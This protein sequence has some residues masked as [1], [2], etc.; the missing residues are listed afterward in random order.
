[1]I[2]EHDG[3]R[4]ENL[5]HRG[6]RLLISVFS[7]LA[8]LLIE[9]R[10]KVTFEE[11]KQSLQYLFVRSRY[12]RLRDQYKFG[13]SEA[14]D[15]HELHLSIVQ[16]LKNSHERNLIY[17]RVTGMLEHRFE[18]ATTGF[19]HIKNLVHQHGPARTTSTMDPLDI[20]KEESHEELAEQM[21]ARL[22]ELRKFNMK[23]IKQCTGLSFPI[24][25][26]YMSLLRQ[27]RRLRLQ[28]VEIVPGQPESPAN[29]PDRA[30]DDDDVG[31]GLVICTR[32]TT[33]SSLNLGDFLSKEKTAAALP[34]N[35]VE[36]EAAIRELRLVKQDLEDLRRAHIELHD[37]HSSHTKSTEATNQRLRQLLVKQS[38]SHGH[39][40]Q[41]MDVSDDPTKWW[42]ETVVE[43]DPGHG[44][45]EDDDEVHRPCPGGCGFRIGPNHTTHC[46]GRCRDGMGHGPR[47]LQ[48]P[49]EASKMSKKM[50]EEVL[51]PMRCVC[52]LE[53][54][55]GE[56]YC[57]VC[58]ARR[59]MVFVPLTPRKDR[60]DPQSYKLDDHDPT[61]KWNQEDQTHYDLLRRK[62]DELEDKLFAAQVERGQ[63]E[64]QADA[65]HEELLILREQVKAASDR[66]HR[67]AAELLVSENRDLAS[68]LGIVDS[69]KTIENADSSTPRSY[70]NIIANMIQSKSGLT[71]YRNDA[72]V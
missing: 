42:F 38:M 28:A 3:L 30:N 40:I 35:T 18:K 33:V 29:G 6:R 59:P 26:F 69:E 58:H 2:V 70:K 21:R 64:A 43:E 1:V 55:R 32:S 60:S 5:D 14:D 13:S 9:S 16:T 31:G 17:K 11:L 23:N 10:R 72:N 39:Q 12:H 71:D 49:C 66:A 27:S 24:D 48:R 25:Q 7:E 50:S 15:H 8:D 52:G 44:T 46:C 63:Y 41:G 37:T 53:I 22:N 62:N 4:V 51:P 34:E 47:C 61:A 20:S 65:N 19:R 57:N 68:T 45:R 54:A 67:Q 56:R 36:D